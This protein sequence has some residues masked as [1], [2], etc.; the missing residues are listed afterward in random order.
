MRIC[1]ESVLR[2]Q[3]QRRT[4]RESR[5]ELA[6]RGRGEPLSI[7]T[8]Q[9]AW[10]ELLIGRRS[11]Q[12]PSET[13][14]SGKP[15]LPFFCTQFPQNWGPCKVQTPSFSL[16]FPFGVLSIECPVESIRQ[17]LPGNI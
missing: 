3:L 12:L 6:S 11:S 13:C 7:G 15:G 9:S 8:V 4:V 14:L 17:Y 5:V 10:E 2:L 16:N 1:K